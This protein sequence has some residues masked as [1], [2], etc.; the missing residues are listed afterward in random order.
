[1]KRIL[2]TGSEGTIGKPLKTELRARGY[3]VYGTDLF[4]TNDP[5]VM[6]ADISDF[7][8][9]DR[10]FD[11]YEPHY[12]YHLAA[13]FGRMNGEEFYEQVWKTNAIGTRHVL[14]LS[15]LYDAPLF[16]AGSSEA[17]G[18]SFEG[19]LYEGLLDES[20]PILLNEYAISKYTN[21]LQ[22]YNYRRRN[23]SKSQ[24]LRFFNAYGP[25]EK[26]TPYRSV[27]ALFTYSAL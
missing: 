16:F 22:V 15:H 19:N 26:Y 25:G 17:Y 11:L 23:K 10:V 4:H 24:I 20:P 5:Q 9:L 13:E 2:I 14:E 3:D 12:V 1:M 7:R 21:E 27:V 8:Q 6:R 18:E